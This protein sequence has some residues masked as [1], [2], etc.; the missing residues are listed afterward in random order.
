MGFFGFLGSLMGGFLGDGGS[1]LS[2]GAF[3]FLARIY[4]H[5]YRNFLLTVPVYFF[6]LKRRKFIP[7]P[8]KCHADSK[9]VQS[10][11]GFLLLPTAYL[12]FAGIYTD[13]TFFKL[14]NGMT[15]SLT[16]WPLLVANSAVFAFLVSGVMSNRTNYSARAV[17][18]IFLGTFCWAFPT[19]IHASK[20]TIAKS[21][22]N[23]FISNLL[24]DRKLYDR[25][26][27]VPMKS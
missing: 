4:P 8:S 9:R 19:S 7:Q 21:G 14:V 15:Y 11:R 22:S 17:S 13:E 27:F 3:V 6:F 10:F 23:H 20:D 25:V 16:R 2:A 5:F 1:F 18:Q 26:F 12:P 24:A